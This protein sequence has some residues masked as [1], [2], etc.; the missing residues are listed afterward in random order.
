VKGFLV[1][2]WE[3]IWTFFIWFMLFAFLMVLFSIFADLFRDHETSGGMK[4]VWVFFLIFLTPIT[5]L[6]YVVVRGKGMAERSQRQAMQMQ[7]AQDAYIMSV[8]GSGSG[9]SPAEQVAHAKQLL[10]AGTITQAEF[11]QLKAK[12]L[13]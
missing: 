6:V 2:F 11:D 3:W 8:A 13:S 9:P 1:D 5:A 12:A 10:D 7:A 4:A